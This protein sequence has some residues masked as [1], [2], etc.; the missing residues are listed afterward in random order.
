MGF[1]EIFPIVAAVFVIAVVLIGEVIV[2]VDSRDD[3]SSSISVEGDSVEFTV[4]SHGSHIYRAVAM[5][6]TL[7]TPEKVFVYYDKEYKSAAASGVS[8]TGGR[9]LDENYYV[10]QIDDTLKVRGIDYSKVVDA[11]GLS[12]VMD[13]PGEGTAVI[14]I[15]GSLPDTVYDGTSDS[16]ILSWIE[17][18]GRL[19]WIGGILGKYVAH[20]DSI[21]AVE[22]GTSLFL[23]SECIDGE[24]SRG[25]DL[26]DNGFR[27][28]L[29][30][31]SNL[32]TFSI[33][34]SKLP[35]GSDYL[36]LGYTDGT[37]SSIVSVKVGDGAICVIGGEYTIRQ[38]IDLSQL[39]ASG[40]GPDTELI[41][42]VDGTVNGTSKGTITKAD[43]V[44][45]TM[46]GFYPV[47]CQ[48]HEV[49]RCSSATPV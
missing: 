44:Y 32:T 36:S 25:Y 45:I 43:S 26:I 24:E 48:N 11:K 20:H 28:A 41:D 14:V 23:G 2:T 21:D 15:S 40:I 33:D 4:E 34:T 13:S 17:S 42:V 49:D 46:G 5:N 39:V 38:R 31:Q 29:Y 1:K 9:S 3:F 6:G 19:Y 12:D 10:E 35:A 47:Y 8:S 27:D 7:G 30:I 16:S 22:N 37:R 18:G